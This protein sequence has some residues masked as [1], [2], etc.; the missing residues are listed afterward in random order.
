MD[1]F[2]DDIVYSARKD[3]FM[4]WLVALLGPHVAALLVYACGCFTAGTADITMW[5]ADSRAFA[6]GAWAFF[7]VVFITLF[8]GSWTSVLKAQQEERQRL[9]DRAVDQVVRQSRPSPTRRLG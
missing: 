7:S 4:T 2:V 8:L 9:L 3:W 5:S 1:K 6:A